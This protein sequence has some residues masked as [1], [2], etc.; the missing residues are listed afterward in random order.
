MELR[1]GRQRLSF[2]TRVCFSLG[3]T[4]VHRP[5]RRQRDGRKHGPTKPSFTARNP[6]FRML[7]SAFTDPIPSRF[8]PQRT[9]LISAGAE[10]FEIVGIRYLVLVDG[11]CWNTYLVRVELVVPSEVAG[12]SRNAESC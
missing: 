10:E 11:E 8:A 1:L 9:L 5:G 2:P 3:M 6:E 12:V 4:H 7:N